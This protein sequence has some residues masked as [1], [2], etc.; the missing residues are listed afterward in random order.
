ML[1]V[2]KSI[3]QVS[4]SWWLMVILSLFA[5]IVRILDIQQ[6]G[7]VVY[8]FCS[9][10]KELADVIKERNSLASQN[11]K[12][13]NINS[14]FVSPDKTFANCFNLSQNTVKVSKK[15]PLIEEFLKIAKELCKEETM[16]LEDKIR[17]FVSNYKNC[18]KAQAKSD[19]LKLLKEIECIYGN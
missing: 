13:A 7:G 10:K 19:C 17:S 11:V 3:T 8:T 6:I 15:P 1:S 16:S 4:V 18:S 5:L 14:G 2:P 9:R 12:N